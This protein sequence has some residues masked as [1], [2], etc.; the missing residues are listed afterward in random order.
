MKSR[1]LA[2]AVCLAFVTRGDCQRPTHASATRPLAS[3]LREEPSL[4]A[5]LPAAAEAEEQP[6]GRWHLFEA[7]KWFSSGGYAQAAATRA[8]APVE[9]APAAPVDAAAAAA[10]WED[11]IAD[12][13][14]ICLEE[15]AS[16]CADAR[17]PPPAG[18]PPAMRGAAPPAGA[19]PLGLGSFENDECLRAAGVSARCGAAIARADAAAAGLPPSALLPPD[20]LGATLGGHRQCVSAI[21]FFLAT[22]GF[23]RLVAFA[24]RCF[25]A[26]CS[27]GQL[28][29]LRTKR[30]AVQRI[31]EVIR[32]NPELQKTVEDAAGVALPPPCQHRAAPAGRRTRCCKVALLATRPRTTVTR[33]G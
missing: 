9:R 25:L 32:A 21:V 18:P 6:H 28:A 19:A 5:D 29:T 11:A 33:S 27:A 2:I 24:A 12:V 26:G 22:L 3:R 14:V 17:T 30:R 31:L 8:P 16:L 1:A 7:L 23:F 10:E 15:F 20:P 4:A 13:Q